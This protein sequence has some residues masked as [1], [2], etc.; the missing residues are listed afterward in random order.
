MDTNT[1]LESQWLDGK[2]LTAGKQYKLTI[3]RVTL[4]ILLDGNRKIAVW[5]A[6]CGK[7]W[8]LNKTNLLSLNQSLVA[9]SDAARC[10]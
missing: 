2:D 4:E 9:E 10:R 8:L 1:Q 3:D 5:F 7:G 6:N